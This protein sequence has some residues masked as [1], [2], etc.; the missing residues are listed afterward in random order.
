MNEI[1]ERDDRF[2]PVLLPPACSTVL[3]TV[4]EWAGHHHQTMCIGTLFNRQPGLRTGQK[5]IELRPKTDSLRKQ[6]RRQKAH[7]KTIISVPDRDHVPDDGEHIYRN[8]KM[9]QLLRRR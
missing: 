2:S 1:I 5:G 8:S 7:T 3:L 4:F 9:T 6:R